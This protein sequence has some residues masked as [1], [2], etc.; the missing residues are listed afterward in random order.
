MD[1]K[2]DM[3]NLP[4]ASFTFGREGTKL[5][6]S[7]GNIYGLKSKAPEKPD[8]NNK[9]LNTSL[10]K[11]NIK[12]INH[13]ENNNNQIDMNNYYYE[14]YISQNNASN[15]EEICELT[16]GG[17][18]E[19]IK[20]EY[21]PNMNKNQNNVKKN[22][23]NYISSF[24]N[25]GGINDSFICVI[26]YSIHHMKLFRKYIVNDLNN[27]QNKNYSI[28]QNSF[29]YHLREILIKIGKN[30]YI[31]IHNFREYLSTIRNN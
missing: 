31:D 20:E 22:N 30:K 28:Y 5:S 15:K 6:M 11:K 18:N 17:N 8:L 24:I 21:E 19:L 12:Q 3:Y 23:N 14:N 16:F 10:K 25:N 27:A 4:L 1:D 29:L 9:N 26:L 13:L 7:K 2:K